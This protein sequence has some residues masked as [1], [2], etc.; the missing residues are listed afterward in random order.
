MPDKED[1]MEQYS[2][3]CKD[4]STYVLSGEVYRTFKELYPKVDIDEELNRMKG[5]I[6]SNVNKRKTK[7]GMKAFINS[8]LSKEPR[9]YNTNKPK[10]TLASKTKYEPFKPAN[11][12]IEWRKAPTR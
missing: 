1:L 5:W 4:G 11:K 7:S 9:E 8:W 3:L 12:E 2:F 6:Y 10:S